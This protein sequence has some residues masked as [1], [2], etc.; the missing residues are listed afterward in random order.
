M[1]NFTATNLVKAQAALNG[2]FASANS[3]IRVPAVHN[4]F[5]QQGS[6]FFPDYVNL[7]KTTT[8][9]IEAGY[10]KRASRALGT[11]RSHNHTGVKGDSGVLTPTFTIRNDK[12]NVSLKQDEGNILQDSF[13]YELIESI[14]N[15][16]EGLD[17]VASD[18]L[19]NSR[20]GVNTAAAEGTFNA[21][22]DV[23]EIDSTTLG[24]RAPQI[25]KT[26]MDINKYQGM[27]LFYIC[28][29]IAFNK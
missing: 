15:F 4:L 23:F 5:V 28:D 3:R 18:K 17:T 2:D 8:R 22:N 19:L 1:P 29:S 7:R 21:T 24:M 12:F 11:G 25:A 9:A 13:D 10:R 27:P 16:M 26:V 20:T 6:S 14:K